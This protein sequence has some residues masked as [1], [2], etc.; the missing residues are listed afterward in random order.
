MRFRIDLAAQDLLR[1]GD[2]QRVVQQPEVVPL[3]DRL[4]AARCAPQ[5]ERR[6]VAAS[7]MCSAS[8]KRALRKTASRGI[9]PRSRVMNANASAS[10]A[11][12]RTRPM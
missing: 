11:A 1:A 9:S 5:L 6:R 2:R 7:T 8:N 10:P 3:I 4:F 12:L